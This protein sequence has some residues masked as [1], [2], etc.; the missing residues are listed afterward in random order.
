MASLSEHLEAAAYVLAGCEPLKERLAIAWSKHLANLEARD[1]PRDVRDEF[2]ELFN[3]LH[4]ETA[5]PGD[6]VLRASLRKLSAA[7]ASRYAKLIIRTYARV[8]ALKSAPTQIVPRAPVSAISSL[9]ANEA[10]G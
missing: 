3:A 7:E 10:S 2:E 8:A 5:L 6:T 4:R 9:F 1:F